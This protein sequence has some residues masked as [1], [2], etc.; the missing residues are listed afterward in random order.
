MRGKLFVCA[1]PI[2]NL[3]DITLR[4]LRILRE[5]DFIAAEDTRNTRKLLAHY[6]VRARLISY[7][8]HNED[9]RTAEILRILKKGCQVALVTDAGTP[10]ISDP[11][12]RLVDRVRHAGFDVVP[13]PGPSAVTAALSVSGFPGPF[14]FLGFL[15]RK[16][17]KR[18][19]VL[20]S[21]AARPENLIFYEAPHRVHATLADLGELLV[22][23]KLVIAR[24]LTKKFEEVLWGETRELAE[25]LA[26]VPLKGEIT[27]VITGKEEKA[28][29][30]E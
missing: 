25:R 30:G 4:A 16:K 29:S 11:G 21:Y 6:E 27:L 2:G 5:V 12:H 18:R 22:G 17:G 20:L 14:T 13:V 15:P 7:H 9:K 8:R 28:P 24:E 23:R 19:A 10:G 3:E 26:D 1:T